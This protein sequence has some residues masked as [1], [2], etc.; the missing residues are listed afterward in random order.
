ML[1]H[2]QEHLPLDQLSQNQ[3][4]PGLE[5]LPGMGHPQLWANAL[6]FCCCLNLFVVFSD[7][8]FQI[9]KICVGSLTVFF[10]D[11]VVFSQ[12]PFL[13]MIEEEIM[14]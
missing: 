6:F 8:W 9:E 10:L 11:S 14:S 12:H 4:Q 3:I 1:C 7:A 5:A 13:A 2:E